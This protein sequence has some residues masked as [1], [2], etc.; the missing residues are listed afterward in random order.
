M[1]ISTE[2][3]NWKDN[4]NHVKFFKM[5]LITEGPCTGTNWNNT[6]N[7][8]LAAHQLFGWVKDKDLTEAK[9]ATQ[10]V[11]FLQKAINKVINAKSKQAEEWLDSNTKIIVQ[12]RAAVTAGVDAGV[13]THG[14]AIEAHSLFNKFN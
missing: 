7:H 2:R 5:L 6:I 8:N 4:N 11:R 1:N 12:L 14:Q 9:G 10:Y 13:I 3:Y